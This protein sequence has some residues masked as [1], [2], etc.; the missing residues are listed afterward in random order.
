MK[1]SRHTLVIDYVNNRFGW[2]NLKDINSIYKAY[3]KTRGVGIWILET[4]QTCITN[5]AII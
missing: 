4:D 5:L 3:T 2:Y 1:Y